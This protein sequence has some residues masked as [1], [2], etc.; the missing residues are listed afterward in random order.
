MRGMLQRK[1]GFPSK[2]KPGDYSSDVEYACTASSHSCAICT[3]QTCSVSS[4]M[5]S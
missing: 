5:C 2:T 1:R 3:P 4:F